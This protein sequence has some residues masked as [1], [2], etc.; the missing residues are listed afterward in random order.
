MSR[1]PIDLA[2]RAPKVSREMARE[3]LEEANALAL[4]LAQRAA[5]LRETEG[6]SGPL[7][8]VAN[9]M[10]VRALA[11]Q[12]EVAAAWLALEAMYQAL[13]SKAAPDALS[14]A[15]DPPLPKE[16]VRP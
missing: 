11:I 14:E 4:D 15:A 6:H 2:A 7:R 12:A 13:D 8:A 10:E 3:R 16:R 9:F 1:P 5:R